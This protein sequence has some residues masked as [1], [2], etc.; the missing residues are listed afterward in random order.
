MKCKL[1]LK[2]LRFGSMIY[3]QVHHHDIMYNLY[4]YS[5]YLSH[6]TEH[7]EASLPNVMLIVPYLIRIFSLGFSFFLILQR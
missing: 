7:T 6:D 3:L 2:G 4:D 1:D 5:N